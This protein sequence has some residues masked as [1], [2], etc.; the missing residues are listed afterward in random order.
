MT[1]KYRKFEGT[2]YKCCCNEEKLQKITNFE[3]RNYRRVT[4]K[5]R[6]RCVKIKWISEA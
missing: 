6:G 2:R 5:H 3:Y 4:T 1:F